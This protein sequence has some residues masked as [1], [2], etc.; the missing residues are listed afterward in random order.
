M[1]TQDIHNLLNVC[2]E[3]QNCNGEV[4]ESSLHFDHL[5]Q[6]YLKGCPLRGSTI[7]FYRHIF[8]PKYVFNKKKS[9]NQ[10]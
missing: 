10:D 4:N 7:I 1:S 8:R 2:V 6:S 3:Y 9:F 5:R